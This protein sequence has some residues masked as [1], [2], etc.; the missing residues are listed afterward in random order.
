MTPVVTTSSASRLRDVITQLRQADVSGSALRGWALSVGED[1]NDYTACVKA[2]SDVVLLIQQVEREIK[3]LP[4]ISHDLYTVQLGR[5][6]TA[7]INSNPNA[8][9]GQLIGAIDAVV[10]QGLEFCADQLD[11]TSSETKLSEGELA[12]LKSQIE[13]L[14]ESVTK[15]DVDPA[16]RTFLVVRL[17]ELRSAIVAYRLF[18]IEPLR[19]AVEG[20]VG[21]FVMVH[22]EADTE[23]NRRTAMQF[24]KDI[25]AIQNVIN[26]AVVLGHVIP[27]IVQGLLG[28]G[29]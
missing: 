23:R 28:R 13:Q 7:I 1:P 21:A 12:T 24:I 6:R 15:A 2:L 5:L 10:L 27:P 19:K 29:S 11:R 25:G 18:G 20:A 8:T 17:E 4:N 9:L 26:G 14:I 22:K 16:F 3:A